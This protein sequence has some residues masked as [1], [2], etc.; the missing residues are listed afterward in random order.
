MHTTRTEAVTGENLNWEPTTKF[1]WTGSEFASDWRDRC[2]FRLNLGKVKMHYGHHRP[3][4]V[5][6]QQPRQRR[7]C[8]R[9]AINETTLC[10]CNNVLYEKIAVVAVP[11]RLAF[12]AYMHY[13][14]TYIHT[15]ITKKNISNGGGSM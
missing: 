4:V 3:E 9:T 14:N 12:F 7:A 6:E 8:K 5:A 13:Y 15:Y 10:V 11:V 1:M 2:S